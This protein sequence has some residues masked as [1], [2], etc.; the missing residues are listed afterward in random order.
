[1]RPPLRARHSPWAGARSAC[2]AGSAETVPSRRGP[3]DLEALRRVQRRLELRSRRFPAELRKEPVWNILLEMLG[4]ELEGRRTSVK[5]LWTAGGAPLSST[6]RFV[7]ELE[8]AGHVT[9]SEDP[10]DRRRQFVSLSPALAEALLDFIRTAE[11]PLK[12]LQN[13]GSGTAGPAPGQ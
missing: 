6:V 12:D 9:R 2:E 3:A 4:A 7:G 11:A 8:A 13:P 10:A 5:C 1:M